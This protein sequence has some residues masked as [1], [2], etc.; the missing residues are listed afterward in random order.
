MNHPITAFGEKRS[1]GVCINYSS[2]LTKLIQEAGKYCTHYASDLFIEWEYILRA[3]DRGTFEGGTWIFAFR[4]MGVDSSVEEEN[5]TYY[6]AIW[7][8]DIE[9]NEHIVRMTLQEKELEE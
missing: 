4:D 8:L 5:K 9:T 1:C 6:K 3:M 7:Q 2:I